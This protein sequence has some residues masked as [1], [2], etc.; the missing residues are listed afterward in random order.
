MRVTGLV[1]VVAAG[2]LFSG[3]QSAAKPPEK[4]TPPSQARTETPA[5]P[6]STPPAPAVAKSAAP[7]PLLPKAGQEI[8][9]FDGKTLGQWKVTDF[10][11]QGAVS[12]KDGA[13]QMAKGSYMTGIT[14]SGPVVR[15]NYEITLEAMRVDGSDFFCG[16]TFPVG[17]S[18]CSLI[19]GGWGGSLCGLS[20]LDHMDASENETT[21]MISFENGKWYHV[22][23]R[24]V[25]NR[26]QAWLDDKDLVDADV[27]GKNIVIRI[28]VEESKPLGIATYDTA[29]AV[30]NIKLKK[31]P[32]EAQ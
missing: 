30:R 1:A 2:L 12:V 15:M 3:C 26:I 22:R 5:Q 24:V 13:I 18:P 27:T 10:G 19:L 29:G 32:D 21:R 31:L 11:G 4:S 14:W 23:L 8:G 25:P 28:E 16:L 17:E 9:L 7:A 6:A 20:S